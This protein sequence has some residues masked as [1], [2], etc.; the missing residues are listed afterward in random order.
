MIIKV[1]IA[2]VATSALAMKLVQRLSH[3]QQLRRARDDGKRHSDDVS[4]WEAEGGNPPEAK[5]P[6]K[7]SSR[8]AAKP[9][10]ES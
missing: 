8:R 2:L 5:E 7:R 10:T 4:R 3:G 6:V 1:A 9:A